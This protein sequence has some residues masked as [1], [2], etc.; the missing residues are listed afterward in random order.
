M[1]P[2]WS[3][4]SVSHWEH[5]ATIFMLHSIWIWAPN[6]RFTCYSHIKFS[7]KEKGGLKKFPLRLYTCKHMHMYLYYTQEGKIKYTSCAYVCTSHFSH[8][9]LFA[10]LWTAMSQAS[11]SMG[12]SRQ[13]Y[14]SG[15][16]TLLQ[17]YKLYLKVKGQYL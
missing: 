10:T 9:R 11:L 13:G 14:W 2:I 7:K 16:P 4:S 6:K 17:G 15:F 3:E 8:V 12:F 5:K 1:Q